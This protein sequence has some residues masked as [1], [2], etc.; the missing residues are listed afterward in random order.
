VRDYMIRRLLLL[1]P[2]LLLVSML[3]FLTVRF[4]PGDVVEIMAAQMSMQS[5]QGQP[6][7]KEYLRRAMGLDQPIH[8]Q[9]W[10]W[11]T[12]AARGDLGTSLWSNRSITEEIVN[13]APIS[14]EL[15]IVALVTGLLIALPIG[16]YSAIR[17]DTQAGH[18][19]SCAF[20]CPAFGWPRLP[21]STPRYGG[22]GPLR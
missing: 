22:T 1:V 5:A 21:S 4:I 17:Q 2:T 10:K 8:V 20:R 9:Y 11:V 16:I 19:P 3:V 15:G 7:D 6:I 18:L 13:K 12:K 14:I